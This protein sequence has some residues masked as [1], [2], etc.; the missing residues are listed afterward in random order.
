MG[1]RSRLTLDIMEDTGYCV[2]NL[3]SRDSFGTGEG[4]ADVISSFQI[5]RILR[6]I[7][8]KRVWKYETYGR[9]CGM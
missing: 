6:S 9:Y 5:P 1:D 2:E 8:V 7:R 4:D 3:T